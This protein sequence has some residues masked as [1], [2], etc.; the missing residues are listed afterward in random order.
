MRRVSG[1]QP[2]LTAVDS[3]GWA[4]NAAV[5]HGVPLSIDP[6]PPTAY[7]VPA[8]FVALLLGWFG[9]RAPP[10]VVKGDPIL[11]EIVQRALRRELDPDAFIAQ[12]LAARALGAADSLLPFLEPAAT[13]TAA[14]EAV[15][16][17]RSGL[18]PS[19]L[20]RRVR[21]FP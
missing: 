15:R 18:R 4:W 17:G 12:V 5:I 11:N 2:G 8:W 9:Y 19:R 14:P 1:P 3:S 20:R 21:P 6:G 7:Y 10:N 13:P 16:R